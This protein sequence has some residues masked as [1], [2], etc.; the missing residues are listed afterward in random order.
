MIAN[1][2]LGKLFAAAEMA[3]AMRNPPATPR[4]YPPGAGDAG[5]LDGLLRPQVGQHVERFVVEAADVGHERDLDRHPLLLRG[6]SRADARDR[7]REQSHERDSEHPHELASLHLPS[8]DVYPRPTR[9]DLSASWRRF[10][11][12]SPPDQCFG[13][14]ER[15]SRPARGRDPAPRSA[16]A[17]ASS[18]R[19][20]R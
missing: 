20:R 12:R 4:A 9:W 17:A 13:A 10:P 3:S 16:R 7:K 6:C 8:F 5:V 14:L 1:F 15:L 18:P 11:A 19:S 2:V